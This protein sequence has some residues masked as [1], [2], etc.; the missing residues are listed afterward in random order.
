MEHFWI[1]D[2]QWKTEVL[3][4]K[5]ASVPFCPPQ[6][7]RGL[8]VMDC[9]YKGIAVK[10]RLPS[11][12]NKG[13]CLSADMGIVAVLCTVS[14]HELFFL[15]C[16][17]YPHDQN[18]SA[19]PYVIKDDKGTGYRGQRKTLLKLEWVGW[20]SIT[21]VYWDNCLVLQTVKMHGLNTCTQNRIA[22][23]CQPSTKWRLFS[24]YKFVIAARKKLCCE[25]GQIG[26]MF[27]VTRLSVLHWTRLYMLKVLINHTTASGLEKTYYVV[28]T[29]CT[30]GTQLLPLLV[31]NTF[32]PCGV[33]VLHG[34]SRQLSGQS[35]STPRIS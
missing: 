13:I 14:V 33:L 18:F 16:V 7:S 17:L 10:E 1:A 31:F 5:L 15:F 12:W 21:G 34:L 22:N 26:N 3:T 29:H 32:C 20:C 8:W 9:V 11:T 27:V 24:F 30:D 2:W 28:V 35:A 6:I 23:R 19:P 4:E 25:C